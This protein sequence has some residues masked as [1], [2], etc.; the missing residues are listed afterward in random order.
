MR[1]LRRQGIR[2]SAVPPVTDSGFDQFRRRVPSVLV[3][4]G[5]STRGRKPTRIRT[6]G[7]V[8][9][10]ACLAVGVNL[11]SNLVVD[12]LLAASGDLRTAGQRP[13][14]TQRRRRPPMSTAMSPPPR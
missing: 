2:I 1:V 13:L 11:L 6:P 7:F 10:E 5:S 9:D 8:A 12:Y 14:R 3:Q 4:L